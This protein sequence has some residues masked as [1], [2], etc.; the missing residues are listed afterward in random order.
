MKRYLF[1]E[2]WRNAVRDCEVEVM[3]FTPTLVGGMKPKESV[4]QYAERG[5]KLQ[6]DAL[7]RLACAREQLRKFKKP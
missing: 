2:V 5:R 1:E 3:Q 7:L 6:E 4:E